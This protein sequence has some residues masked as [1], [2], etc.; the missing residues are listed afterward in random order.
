MIEINLL[1]LSEEQLVVLAKAYRKK[2]NTAAKRAWRIANPGR[3][4]ANKRAWVAANPERAAANMRAYESSGRAKAVKQAWMKTERGRRLKLEAARRFY[5]TEKYRE[6][7]RRTRTASQSLTYQRKSR[8]VKDADLAPAVFMAQGSV[9]GICRCSHPGKRTWHAD[10]DHETQLL[11]GLLCSRCNTGLG[12][13][14][15]SRPMLEAAKRYLEAPPS[16]RIEYALA[17]IQLAKEEQE[18]AYRRRYRGIVDAHR[19]P[20]L[21]AF[22]QGRCAICNTEKAGL[23]G[24]VA[25]HDH[26]TGLLRGALC[27]CCNCGIGG[28]ADS[29]VLIDRALEYLL[30]PPAKQVRRVR[31]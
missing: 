3:D 20:E 16:T 6:C 11:R 14:R 1:L 27:S 28:F 7:R 30:D 26:S 12:L 5:R 13:L 18:I 21:I 25:D 23:H 8:G 19:M 2:R 15:D 22:Q 10:H 4:T 17:P 29:I 31:Q 9:C 24:L